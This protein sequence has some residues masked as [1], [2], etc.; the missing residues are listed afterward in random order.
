MGEAP[1][2]VAMVIEWSSLFQEYGNEVWYQTLQLVWGF[3][4]TLKPQDY[5]AD[6]HCA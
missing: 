3:A 5:C 2:T 6:R 1:M 4:Q